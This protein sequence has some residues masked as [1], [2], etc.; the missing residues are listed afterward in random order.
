[1]VGGYMKNLT[2]APIRYHPRPFRNHRIYKKEHPKSLFNGLVLVNI[3]VKMEMII[4]L[5][6]SLF[7]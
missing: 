3:P 4:S 6:V 1:M 7:Q 2:N 5:V